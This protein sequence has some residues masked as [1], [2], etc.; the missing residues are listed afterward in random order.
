[1][2]ASN[3]L[4]VYQRISD[5]M[6]AVQQLGRAIAGS[7]MFGCDNEFQGQVF[8]LECLTRGT[9]PLTLQQEYHVMFNGITMKSD[10]MLAKFHQRG[11]KSKIISRTSERAEIE[12]QKENDT[13]RFVFTWEE[14]QKEDFIYEGKTK[15]L[16][17]AFRAYMAGKGPQ[18]EISDKYFSPRSRMQMLWA[19]V[20]SDGVRAMMP[21]VNS[22]RYTPEEVGG[23]DGDII[24]GEFEVKSD[25]AGHANGSH[26]NGNGSASQ[27]AATT[28]DTV[29][30]TVA[31]AA[32]TAASTDGFATADQV[33]AI[34]DLFTKCR[35]SPD[36][37]S[38]VLAKR[39]VANPRGL[40]IDQA[41]ELIAGLQKKLATAAAEATSLDGGKSAEDPAA[42]SAKRSGPCLQAQIDQVKVLLPE[43]EQTHPGITDKL[44]D[45]LLATGRTP[46]PG[47]KLLSVMT[48]GECEGL[49][50]S[51]MRKEMEAF[52][53]K[54]LRPT[55]Q[56]T[57][58][59]T[60]AAEG[61][62]KN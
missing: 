62:A 38:A 55:E 49:L 6:A 36:Q 25:D 32:D 53:E 35:L 34:R 59:S 52:F 22:G 43:V 61:D 50:N 28:P 58:Q 26:A 42:I 41:S 33:S 3:A 17:V 31:P 29:A 18:P 44:K 13:Q 21:E 2:V 19:R 45:R 9:P 30:P 47:G 12:L 60:A 20:V 4:T 51:L 15:E 57:E 54:S 7:K 10:T 40:T 8:A 48:Y 37:Q 46:A 27:V 1:M 11:G 5:P 39:K 16:K 24:E 23:D 56:P 14:A